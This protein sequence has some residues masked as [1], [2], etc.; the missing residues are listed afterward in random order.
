MVD[1]AFR[2][3]IPTSFEGEDYSL[4]QLN[5]VVTGQTTE[6]DM[7]S[8]WWGD[9]DTSFQLS[10]RA[11]KFS[12]ADRLIVA[13][14]VQDAN[15][16]IKAILDEVAVTI[17]DKANSVTHKAGDV[18]RADIK[19]VDITGFAEGQIQGTFYAGRHRLKNE[20][21][22]SLLGV[23]SPAVVPA[24]DVIVPPAP[25]KEPHEL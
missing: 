13:D 25:A 17:K 2:K 24:D 5:P 10:G 8:A 20:A 6:G 18:Y 19:N 3:I 15:S 21:D 4:D 22:R 16:R 1:G 23:S 11:S 7:K 9:V 12:D 14:V